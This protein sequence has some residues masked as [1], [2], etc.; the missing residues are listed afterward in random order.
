LVVRL[1]TEGLSLNL[2]LVPDLV[3]TQAAKRPSVKFGRKR[4]LTSQQI[5]HARKILAEGEPV[6]AVLGVFDDVSRSTLY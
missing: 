6:E 1:S 2:N 3:H 5:A 4:K